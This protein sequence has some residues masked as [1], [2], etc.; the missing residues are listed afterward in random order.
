MSKQDGSSRQVTT[1]PVD[2]SATP[3]L[4]VDMDAFFVSVELLKR[5]DLRGK[6]VLVGGTAGRGVVSAASYEA[7][8]YGVNSA[9]PM[10]LALQRC[11]NAVVLRGDYASY[12]EYSRRVMNIF[13]EV[14]PLV[15]KLSI[16]EA[17]LDVSGARRLHGSPAEIAWRLRRRVHDETGLTCSVGVAATKFV[18]K[19]ASSRAKP[20]GMLVVPADRTLEFLHPLPVSAL[21]GVGKVTE[22]SLTRIGLRTVGDVAAMPGDALQRALGPALAAKLAHLSMGIDARDVVTGREE[23]SIGHEVTFGYD[24][25]DLEQLRRELLRLSDDVA[26]RL[27]RAGVVGRT[28]VLKLRYGDFR[29]VTRSRTLGEPTDV[30]RRIYDEASAALGELAGDGARIRLIGVRAEQLRPSGSGAMLWDPDEEWREAERTIDEVTARF[31]RGAVRPASLVSRAAE[32]VESSRR[33]D[34]DRGDVR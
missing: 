3:I 13:E 26:V 9:M 4:H 6:P 24:L 2:D 1:G 25:T 7:R 21:W 12:T 22:E 11:P 14:T 20:D 18:A 29:T 19:V 33:K 23:K 8:R 5:P 17:F 28:V 32:R 15:E 31:G 30:A 27:R 16:D 10:S 34:P